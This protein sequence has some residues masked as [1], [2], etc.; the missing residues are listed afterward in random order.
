MVGH[1]I[2]GLLSSF[3]KK[4]FMGTQPA[5]GREALKI[6]PIRKF[7]K[8]GF[9]LRMFE[10]IRWDRALVLRSGFL[11]HNVDGKRGMIRNAIVE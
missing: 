4:S 7:S 5:K 10:H 6:R 11:D 2:P 1:V 9:E 8:E 3:S